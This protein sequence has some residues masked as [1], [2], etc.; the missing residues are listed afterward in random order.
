MRLRTILTSVHLL[1][2]IIMLVHVDALAGKRGSFEADV[3]KVRKLFENRQ[4]SELNALLEKYQTFCTKDIRWEFAVQ[5]GFNI[6]SSTTP[7]Y[8]IILDEWVQSDSKSWVPLLARANY[9][10]AIGWKARGT[11]WAK[12][13]S[14]ER[15]KRME[16]SFAQAVRDVSTALKINPR[17]L[18]AYF[19]LMEIN[20]N[21]G[22][23][24][25]GASLAKKALEVFP[26]SYL[27]RQRH[28]Q[29]LVPR[30][31]GS[32]S[33]MG[34][35]A[36]EASSYTS[37]NPILK[38]LPGF[39]FWE[40]A[41]MAELEEDN[42]KAIRLYKK[43][44]SYGENWNFLS[45]L[46]NVY[47]RTGEYDK[48]V[49]TIDHAIALRPTL[50]YGYVLRAKILFA[51]KKWGKSLK[52]LENAERI[53]GVAS[54][55][56]VED[57]Q[58]VSNEMVAMAHALFRTNLSQAIDKYTLALRFYPKYAY[59]YCWRGIAYDRLGKTDSALADLNKAISLN[60][61]LYDAY[62]GID[63]VL[64]KRKRYDEIIESWTRFIQLEPNNAKA[65]LERG[66]TYYRK[67]DFAS[68][69]R[70][71]KKAC[72]LGNKEACRRYRSLKK[73]M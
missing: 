20:R 16:E 21:F 25:T 26:D 13:T 34:R 73:R 6:F 8:K 48:A 43:A 27:L 30:W 7:S 11:Q 37:T 10:I 5:D 50:A 14:R 31:G 65:Y 28:M 1:V 29:D 15:F 38:T 58:W 72:E 66:G 70:D 4:F 51:Q 57:R 68:A 46:S 2:L 49:Q 47:W 18:D 33:E 22:D 55:E 17:L 23:Q 64:I 62:K 35:F 42:P 19:I 69:L 45:D 3:V 52:D 61:R 67:Q 59:A 63:G 54:D 53:R 56:M 36:H 41:R 71:A 44:L 9:Y 39:V 60:P 40:Q 12:D 32:Y 24:K